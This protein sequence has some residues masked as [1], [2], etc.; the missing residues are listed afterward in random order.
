MNNKFFKEGGFIKTKLS[1]DIL[2]RLERYIKDKGASWNK[3][4][5]GNISRSCL[6][7]D[8]NN[9][10]FEKVLVP[11]I[12][13]YKKDF[14]PSLPLIL[15]ESCKFK[16]N[17]FWVNFQKKYEFNPIHNHSGVYSFV[18]WIKIPSSYKKECELPF[19]KNSNS[20]LPN[21]F[22]F[23]NTNVVGKIMTADFNLEPSDEGTML[24]FP[25]QLNHAVYPFYLSN[26]ERISVSGNIALNPREII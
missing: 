19:I 1:P 8:K 18:I 9:F 16:L 12:N 11:H 26:K 7:E 23:I 13:Q 22:Q 5:A 6:L 10:F 14:I 3:Q 24:F 25:A 2:K 17:K 15:T 20:P 21:T 4:L